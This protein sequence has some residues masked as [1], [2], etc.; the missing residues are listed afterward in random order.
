MKKALTKA[1]AVFDR[2]LGIF[3]SLVAGALAFI[4]LLVSISVFMR[5][6]LNRPIT[7]VM[8]VTE[9]T[10][11]FIASLGLAWVLRE[12]CHVKVDFN[13]GLPGPV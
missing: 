4:M 6:A 10:L 5:Y 2:L 11:V 7:G 3:G 1:R 9:F 8:D 13:Q 12:E